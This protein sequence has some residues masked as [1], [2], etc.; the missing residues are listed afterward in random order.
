MLSFE[1]WPV[2]RILAGDYGRLLEMRVPWMITCIC[3]FKPKLK[4]HILLTYSVNNCRQMQSAI[5]PVG[6]QPAL[7]CR[8]ATTARLGKSTLRLT[9]LTQRNNVL[10]KHALDA[11]AQRKTAVKAHSERVIVCSAAPLADV[12]LGRVLLS[13]NSDKNRR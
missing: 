9:G 1:E 13:F 2:S 11:N 6:G 5:C 12:S 10:F 8:I 4:W 3:N 7:M